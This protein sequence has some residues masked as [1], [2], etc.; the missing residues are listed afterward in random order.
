M[1]EPP[2]RDKPLNTR[3]LY[4]QIGKV[5]KSERLRR[6]VLEISIEREMNAE[7]LTSDMICD[8]LSELGINRANVEGIQLVPERRPKKIFIWMDQSVDLLPFCRGK[9]FHF[10]GGIKTGHIKPMDKIET[11]VLIKGLNINTPDG[12]VMEYLSLFGKI[13]KHEVVYVKNKV[14]PF[15]GLKNRDSKFLMDFK[16]GEIWGPTV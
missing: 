8:L 1:G 13:L 16:R 5:K 14:G 7:E 11:E 4:S 2:D 15:T 10:P 12:S 3:T 6:N 9:Q